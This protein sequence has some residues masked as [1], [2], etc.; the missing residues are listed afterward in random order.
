MAFYGKLSGSWQKLSPIDTRKEFLFVYGDSN[1][2]VKKVNVDGSTSTI[3]NDNS[4]NVSDIAIEGKTLNYVISGGLDGI[5]RKTSVEN[6]NQEWNVGL[7]SVNITSID[8][9]SGVIF[10]GDDNGDVTQIFEDG[11]IGWTYTGH[12]ANIN[13]IYVDQGLNVY[14]ASADKTFRKIDFEG[15]EVWKNTSATRILNSVVSGGGDCSYNCDFDGV[16]RK[17]G[18]NGSVDWTLDFA[19]VIDDLSFRKSDGVLFAAGGG[20]TVKKIT[21]KGTEIY[22]NLLADEGG[23]INSISADEN[24]NIYVGTS[25]NEVIKA[26]DFGNS[27]SEDWTFSEPNNSVTSTDIDYKT[28]QSQ[29]ASQD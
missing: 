1:G 26:T 20:G 29:I 28:T 21:N 8:Q 22:S 23:S 9:R 15:N 5:I 19:N 18:P 24:G 17:V 7:G 4:S 16:V 11:S 13:G 3:I 14:T 25:N 27:A 2:V 12:T 10:A 6:Q